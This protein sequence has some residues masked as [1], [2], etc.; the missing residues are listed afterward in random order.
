MFKFFYEIKKIPTTL[1]SNEADIDN[2]VNKDILE[3]GLS[4]KCQVCVKVIE[5]FISI[6]GAA[7][8][9]FAL[10]TLPTGG[11]YLLGGLSIA[12]EDYILKKTSFYVNSIIKI[13]GQFLK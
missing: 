3:N 6:Y 1:V 12:L 2:L 5:L 11:L 13:S 10:F 9:N 4:E 7:A 8:G